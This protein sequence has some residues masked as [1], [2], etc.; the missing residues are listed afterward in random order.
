MVRA[1]S[2]QAGWRSLL[3]VDWR[4]LEALARLGSG[5]EE[6]ALQLA[7]EEI[8]AAER[9]ASTCCA[10]LGAARALAR[11]RRGAQVAAIETAPRAARSP[12]DLARALV[13]HGGAL[14]RAGERA[15]SREPLLEGLELA[16]ACVASALAEHARTELRAAG[17]RPRRAARSG[18]EALTPSER[19]VAALA[20]EGLSN[21][22][23]A[24]ALFVTVR[25]SGDAPQRRLSQA[26]DR[27]ARRSPRRALG[28]DP[29]RDNPTGEHRGERG[30]APSTLPGMNTSTPHLATTEASRVRWADLAGRPHGELGAVRPSRSSSCTD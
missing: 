19:R 26:R 13:D 6:R 27:L 18:V 22:E 12:L 16:A 4:C 8:A 23:V 21:A 17:A 7:D 30:E 5:D 15:L 14:R 10:V 11:G 1:V 29:D 20:A 2:A 25:T 3:P 9:F 24:Q 28:L